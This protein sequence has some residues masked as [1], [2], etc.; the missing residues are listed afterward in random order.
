MGI[1]VPALIGVALILAGCQ[2]DKPLVDGWRP[3]TRLE[4]KQLGEQRI[5]EEYY[6]PGPRPSISG[7]FNGDGKSDR[8]MFMVDD[9]GERFEPYFIDGAGAAP[10]KL[11]RG[12]KFDK[13]W[14][15]N[16]FKLPSRLA[17]GMCIEEGYRKPSH[18]SECE[19]FMEV[20]TPVIVFTELD[21]G[22]QVFYWANGGF[23][24]RRFK[25]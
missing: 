20:R 5:A 11:T 3:L 12:D 13:L 23:T 21:E 8:V 2:P 4:T 25:K 19:P 15:Y 18:P 14:R 17:Y 1:R 22:G 10:E 7:D 16:L 9:A 6:D 24:E